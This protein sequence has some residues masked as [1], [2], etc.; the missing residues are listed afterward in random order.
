MGFG[1]ITPVSDSA[2]SV[3]IIEQKA[4]IQALFGTAQLNNLDPAAWLKNMLTKLPAWPNSHIDE[5]LL[6]TP[7]FIKSLKLIQ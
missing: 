6:L 1:E 7:E 3:V 4:A 5:L 2:R